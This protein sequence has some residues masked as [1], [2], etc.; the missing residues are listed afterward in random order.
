MLPNGEAAAPVAVGVGVPKTL[1][2]AAVLLLEPPNSD[3]EAGL[4]VLRPPNGDEGAPKAGVLNGERPPN[5]ELFAAAPKAGV[6]AASNNDGAED[7]AEEKFPPL[8]GLNPPNAGAV[9]VAAPLDPANAIPLPNGDAAALDVFEALLA[10][11][12]PN[13]PKLKSSAPLAAADAGVP[14]LGTDAVPNPEALEDNGLAPKDKALFAG[15]ASSL[16]ES[17]DG[18]AGVDAFSFALNASSRA[19]A[20]SAAAAP[21]TGGDTTLGAGVVA[22]EAEAIS[23][24]LLRAFAAFIRANVG[25]GG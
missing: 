10:A 20:A 1:V 8:A 15:F 5:G 17:A 14:K 19:W 22:F 7:A 21:G 13:V 2:V 12:N 9:V 18:T 4:L 23:A 16:T 6:L 3:P 24:L 25:N 11:P